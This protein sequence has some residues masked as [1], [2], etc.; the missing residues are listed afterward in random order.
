MFSTVYLV[1]VYEAQKQYSLFELDS[2]ILPSLKEYEKHCIIK[3]EQYRNRIGLLLIQYM[4]KSKKIRFDRVYAGKYGKLYIDSEKYID[5]SV[6][7]SH[8]YVVGIIDN[9][10]IGI[11]IEK[12]GKTDLRFSKRFYTEEENKYCIEQKDIYRVWTLKESYLKCIGLGLG[13]PL[14]SFSVI[15]DHV[16]MFTCEKQRCDSIFLHSLK[17]ND[18]YISICCCGKQIEEVKLE[19]KRIKD[20]F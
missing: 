14:R 20:L 19:E 8:R 13:I 11:D 9:N 4:L 18:Y 16:V 3:E 5:F 7:H 10:K 12:I 2:R 1:D 6:A 17:V 15:R